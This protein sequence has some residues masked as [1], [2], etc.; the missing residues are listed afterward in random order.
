MIRISKR[1]DQVLGID[2]ASVPIAADAFPAKLAELQRTMV[3][4]GLVLAGVLDAFATPFAVVYV[5]AYAV[6]THA[7][8][9]LSGAAPYGGI[10][11]L[12]AAGC[13]AL[14][15]VPI[16]VT[17]YLAERTSLRHRVQCTDTL[18]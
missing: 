1:L 11:A 18:S 14:W 17:T 7:L 4:R 9:S 10:A 3:R 15:I 16:G 12:A 13:T 6:D 2:S 5:I 8:V